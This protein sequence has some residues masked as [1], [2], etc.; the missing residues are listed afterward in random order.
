M[1]GWHYNCYFKGMKRLHLLLAI[2]SLLLWTGPLMA[3]TA[4][5]DSTAVTKAAKPTKE[6]KKAAKDA[7]RLEKELAK[8]ARKLEEF[9]QK[10]RNIAPKYSDHISCR[11]LSS[12]QEL[13]S[14]VGISMKVPEPDCKL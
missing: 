3:Q 6:E 1:T 9:Q 4:N 7:K 11:R 10:Q 8:S 12:T 5:E 2:T 14:S 13:T